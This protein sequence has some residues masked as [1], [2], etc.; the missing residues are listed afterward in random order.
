MPLFLKPNRLPPRFFLC[1]RNFS[2]FH[3][4]GEQAAFFFFLI[5]SGLDFRD[6]GQEAA[7]APFSTKQISHDPGVGYVRNVLCD[8]AGLGIGAGVTQL[9][10]SDVLGDEVV[11]YV[12]RCEDELPSIIEPH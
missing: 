10:E 4:A 3:D 5:D 9:L 1:G 8:P 2:H 7:L 11:Q 6:A 12:H